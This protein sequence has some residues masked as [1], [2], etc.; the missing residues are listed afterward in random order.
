MITSNNRATGEELARDE[1][2]SDAEIEKCAATCDVY[3]DLREAAKVAAKARSIN[4]GQSCVNA[5][6]FSVGESVADRFVELFVAG[7]RALKVGDL[8]AQTERKAT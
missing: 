2:Q 6:R 5:R 3:V 4:V 1:F 7:V 8:T